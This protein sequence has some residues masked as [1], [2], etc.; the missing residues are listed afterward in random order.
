[1]HH[2]ADILSKLFGQDWRVY[3][4]FWGLTARARANSTIP[5]PVKTR[6]VEAAILGIFMGI[7]GVVGTIIFAIPIVQNDILHLQ[8]DFNEYKLNTT[9]QIDFNRSEREREITYLQNEINKNRD[10]RVAAIQRMEDKL[11]RNRDLFTRYKAFE[12]KPTVDKPIPG[13]PQ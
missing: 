9:H 2:L 10:E 1:M 4:P 5:S 11:D 3:V 12:A 6:F 13:H 8:D 7:I